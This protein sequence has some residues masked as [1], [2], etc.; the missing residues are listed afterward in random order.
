MNK[1]P[2]D[3]PTVEWYASYKGTTEI[4]LATYPWAA[5]SRAAIKMGVPLARQ[6]DI[7]VKKVEH[8]G[9]QPRF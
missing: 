3:L 5:K 9:I 1:H 6:K 4:V 2:V 8:E 7:Q